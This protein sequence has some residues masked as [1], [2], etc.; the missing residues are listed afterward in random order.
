MRLV[1][2]L[3]A[4]AL[5]AACS[6]PRDKQAELA[7]ELELLSHDQC[8]DKAIS[9]PARRRAVARVKAGTT[10]EAN[11]DAYMADIREKVAKGKSRNLSIDSFCQMQVNLW[12]KHFGG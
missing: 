1:L 6:K 2:L 5:V 8:L 9:D 10:T 11:L 7:V 3:L 4:L 12:K